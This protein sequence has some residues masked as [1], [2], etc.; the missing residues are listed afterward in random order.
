MQSRE[1]FV[2][3]ELYVQPAAKRTE[4]AGE[5]GGRLRVRVA[6]P[7]VDGA[8]N[9]AL[10]AFVAKTFGIKKREVTI[11]KGESARQKTLA[12]ASVTIEEAWECLPHLK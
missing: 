1:G 4:W 3:L 11:R 12:L 9:E 2:I 7:P 8:A 10:I 6:S 5:H